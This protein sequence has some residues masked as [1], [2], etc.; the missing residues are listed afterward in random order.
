M[1]RKDAKIFQERYEGQA[2]FLSV[3]E[4]KH[5]EGDKVEA[6]ERWLASP[7]PFRQLYD[8]H[9]WDP[10]RGRVYTDRDGEIVRNIYRPRVPLSERLGPNDVKSY[11]DLIVGNFIP[12]T[13]QVFGSELHPS[14]SHFARR[15]SWKLRNPGKRSRQMG[16]VIGEEG[17][18]KTMLLTYFGCAYAPYDAEK[19]NAVGT[20]LNLAR[21]TDENGFNDDLVGLEYLIM[22]E[23]SNQTGRSGTRDISD[24]LKQLLDRPSISINTKFLKRF[25]I[26]DCLLYDVTSNGY[27]FHVEDGIRRR[28]HAFECVTP[29]YLT[30]ADFERI[31]SAYEKDP[32]LVHLA[33]RYFL[34][35]L[36]PNGFFAFIVESPE[37]HAG[38]FYDEA[39]ERYVENLP[40]DDKA[41]TLQYP[42]LLFD[43]D[44]SRLKLNGTPGLGS[45]MEMPRPPVKKLA[46]RG[47]MIYVA[48]HGDHEPGAHALT[49]AVRELMERQ[50]G[51]RTERAVRDYI[52]S[53]REDHEG[54][55][56]STDWVIDEEDL[57]RRAG[58]LS[59]Q[60]GVSVALHIMNHA[61]CRQP[62]VPTKVKDRVLDRPIKIAWVADIFD[63]KRHD[64]HPTAI[65]N[66]AYWTEKA[67]PDEI[68]D[69]FRGYVRAIALDEAV[70]KHG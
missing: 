38:G 45:K 59:E 13:R 14:F 53:Y 10:A 42:A 64:A 66:V 8:R 62:R 2:N 30:V 6:V 56:S 60:N 3:A 67:G 7:H 15:H 37:S 20:T 11:M 24:A 27:N 35:V 9:T 41:V 69:S 25:K 39:L 29:Q 1:M 51:S 34:E 63:K 57:A 58:V 21:V 12:L 23:V 55:P 49:S 28:L 43:Q 68:R 19:M 4:L 52:A 17:V 48:L 26:R 18:G 44:G 36:V 65:C 32:D 46:D 40:I 54:K 50:S 61:K 33:M 70:A 5:V 31:G 16:M 47:E 22:N